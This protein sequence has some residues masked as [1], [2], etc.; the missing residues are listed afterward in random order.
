MSDFL[1][2]HEENS[3]QSSGTNP[4]VAEATD[5]ETVQAG[6]DA[7]LISTFAEA[8]T[9]IAALEA[10]LARFEANFD[11]RE[12]IREFHPDAG[13]RA[14]LLGHVEVT[15]PQFESWVSPGL[16]CAEMN[17]MCGC[18]RRVVR[19]LD[20]SLR[21]VDNVEHTVRNARNSQWSFQGT[22]QRRFAQFEQDLG[23]LATR[24]EDLEER[25]RISAVGGL[26]YVDS[27]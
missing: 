12:V 20:L 18:M 6:T 25:D 2:S 4:W 17:R 23:R 19:A 13:T 27:P 21:A 8:S 9:R 5:E 26:A 7:F 22:T 14:Q 11:P 1:A 10:R 24:T 15:V 3:E 16:M